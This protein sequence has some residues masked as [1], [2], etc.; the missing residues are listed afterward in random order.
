MIIHIIHLSIS[1]PT[2]ISAGEVSTRSG[3][4]LSLEDCVAGH[5]TRIDTNWC[6][7]LNCVNSLARAESSPIFRRSYHRRQ[8]A[9][10]LGFNTAPQRHAAPTG[11]GVGTL[12]YRCCYGWYLSSSI[13][14]WD[15]DIPLWNT[16]IMETVLR[17]K[18]NHPHLRTMPGRGRIGPSQLL[19]TYS[20]VSRQCH[21]ALAA[22]LQRTHSSAR[23]R[24]NVLCP[25][26]SPKYMAASWP[27]ARIPIFGHCT[28]RGRLVQ[29]MR[30]T[31][32]A[33][34]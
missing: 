29:K 4:A 6:V 22:L 30:S 26:V 5:S 34:S 23:T 14:I 32:T 28:T 1:I 3:F 15:H 24:C 27:S 25:G 31:F 9:C 12:G 10:C 7:G 21:Y 2:S 20:H 17:G 13:T 16:R 8:M 19:L 33:E 18:C 11:A